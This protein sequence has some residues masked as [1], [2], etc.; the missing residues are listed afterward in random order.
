[1]IRVEELP[2]ATQAS[3]ID[4]APL[5]EDE[6]HAWGLNRNKHSVSI[7]LKSEQ[8]KE[9]FYRLAAEADVV[10]DNFRPGVTAR[11]GID[12]DTLARY[13][14]S[15]ITCSLSGFGGDGPWATM[16]AYDPIVQAMCGAMNYTRLSPEGAPVRWGIPIGD[17]FG[18]IFA[19]IGVTAAV[20]H[21]DRSGAGQHIDV[22]MLDVMLALNAYRVPQALT[23][24]EEPVPSPF[25]GG[26]GTVPFGT[27]ECS[28]GWVATCISQR[29]WKS[30]CEVFGRPDLF[31]DERFSTGLARHA[32]RAELV[33]TLQDVF[34]Q[35]PAGTWQ[36][37]L[38]S[39]GVAC[40]KVTDV[41]DVFAHP[42]VVA[43]GMVVEISDERGRTATVAGDPLKFSDTSTWHAPRQAGADTARVFTELLGLEDGD[44]R[45]LHAERVIHLGDP[46]G[47]QPLRP[48]D[49]F[50]PG[51]AAAQPA[52]RP[53]EE[54]TVL[55][56]NGDEPS[57]CFAG[58]LLADLGARV[59]KVD[60]PIGQVIEP[61]PNES[62]EA[63]FRAG[64]NRGKQ[65]VI[66]DL[67][68]SDG[69][70]FF[71]RLAATA[72]VVLDNYRPG[73]LKRLGIDNGAL[74][75]GNP[76]LIST[77]I[78][79]FGHTGPWSSY[80]AFDNVIQAL[81]G[82]MSITR[83][84]ATPEIPVRW[85]NP[86]GGLTGAMFAALGTLGA[87][88]QRTLTGEGR[89]VDVSLLDGQAALLSYR[90]P[91]AVTL[92]RK[93]L[94]E[95][96]RGGTGSLPF[97]AFAT[98]NGKWFTICITQQF[99][100]GFCAAAGAPEWEH[101]PRFATEPLRR[102][103]EDELY[104]LVEPSFLTR[105]AEEWQR[106]YVETGLP[107]AVVLSIT[108][109]FEHPQVIARGMR[110]RI[111]DDEFPDGIEVANAALRFSLSGDA[112]ATPAP[113]PGRDTRAIAAEIGFDAPAAAEPYSPSARWGRK[114]GLP[115]G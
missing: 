51:L 106:L 38:M 109:A 42:Q 17:L 101:D 107:G 46:A 29:M 7:D 113:L 59:I 103:N 80:P 110:L 5:R 77:S 100:S 63:S 102:Q 79:G 50:V 3:G 19:A 89:T 53:L 44:L 30:A 20:I 94:P 87:L 34:R 16:P 60:R 81:G 45:R 4:P 108:E 84:P 25:E 22:S 111:P 93:F 112:P 64:L 97:G 28:D 14:P 18:G 75:A 54:V 10:Y 86:I 12:R 32:H 9:L 47:G 90:V 76:R 48:H 58:Q 115:S 26:Q 13:N 31:T 92:G 41:G 66:A 69:Q 24:G 23:F 74:R 49:R 65:S 98:A 68:T 6:A 96:R 1:V 21:R 35:R 61:Y 114:A 39:V 8:G 73:V 15:I 55:E 91:Q 57:K 83:D 37:E 40:G 33:A 104:A 72:D 95:P 85:G 52:Q 71:G 70:A 36:D 88:R 62:R 82:G 105:T 11:L 78:T 2:R 43:R 27:F 99:W 67:K 56:L